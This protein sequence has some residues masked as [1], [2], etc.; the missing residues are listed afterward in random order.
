MSSS[1][2]TFMFFIG[3]GSTTN[4]M[5]MGHAFVTQIHWFKSIPQKNGP[6]GAAATPAAVFVAMASPWPADLSNGYT[7]FSSCFGRGGW[8]VGPRKWCYET[9]QSKGFNML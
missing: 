3:V 1:K 8:P 6:D 9:S 2:L 7:G 4:Q 5:F